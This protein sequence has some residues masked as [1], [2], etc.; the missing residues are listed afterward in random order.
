LVDALSNSLL[1]IKAYLG[2]FIHLTNRLAGVRPGFAFK[3]DQQNVAMIT[4]SVDQKTKGFRR[5][6][7]WEMGQV[8]TSLKNRMGPQKGRAFNMPMTTIP[9]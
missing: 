1:G 5:V 9:G 8:C 2:F 6:G 4:V 7:T 3:P